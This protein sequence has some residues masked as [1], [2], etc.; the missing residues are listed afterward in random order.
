VR[1]LLPESRFRTREI[2][3]S[4]R[5]RTADDPSTIGPNDQAVLKNMRPS[6][7]YPR[8]IGGMTKVNTS[9]LASTGIRNGFHYRKG[10]PEES[11]FMVWTNNGG[12]W[13]N[14]TAIP[15]QGAF[16]SI[17]FADTAV[18]DPG[19]FSMAPGGALAYANGVE[20][21]L[22]GGTKYRCAGFVDIPNDTDSYDY[23]DQVSN[24]DEDT[25][26]VATIHTEVNG[27]SYEATFYVGSIMPI[28]G[29]YF[30]VNTVNSVAT[31]LAVSYW[32]GSAWASV[33]NLDD[34]TESG[35][36]VLAQDGW[37]TFD[38]T[39]DVAKP[40]DI[41]KTFIYWY[42]FSM[43]GS[44]TY[45]PTINTVYVDIPMQK[46]KDIW[47]GSPIPCASHLIHYSDVYHDVTT[48]TIED[49]YDNSESNTE[50]PRTFAN[51]GGNP[52]T[53]PEEYIYF[54]FPVRIMGI[55]FSIG[56]DFENADAATIEEFD[57]W[58]GNDWI[59]LTGTLSDGTATDGKTFSKSG[60]VTW[61]P[62]TSISEKTIVDLPSHSKIPPKLGGEPIHVASDVPLYYYRMKFSAVINEGNDYP[63]RVYYVSGI[64]A[65]KDIKGYAFPLCHQNRLVL[66]SNISGR[67]N[68]IL[69]SAQD[70]ANAFNGLDSY[71]FFVGNDDP[72]VAGTPLFLRVSSATQDMLV[73][74]KNSEIHL[75]EG[76]GSDS[77]PYRLRLLTDVIGCRAPLTMATVPVGDL[78]GGVRRQL[79]I[80]ES[81]RGIE[82]FDGV[83]LLDPLLS[84]DIRDKFDPNNAN[85]AGSSSNA[86]F[87]DAVYDEYHWLPV[88]S[89][90]WVYSFKYKKWYQVDRGSG[91]YLYGGIPC[92]DTSGDSYVYGFDNA[93]YVY[94]LE[95]GTDFDSNDIDH[96]IKTGAIALNENRI[97]EETVLRM[98]KVVQVAKSVTANDMT[99]T[100][101][102]DTATSGNS[103][104][105]IDPAA[106]GK[107][108]RTAIL[109]SG[110]KGPHVH[111]EFQLELTTDD[112]VSGC[113]PIYIV[114]YYDGERQDVR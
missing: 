64:P 114:A 31:S 76:N 9:A 54:G 103:V 40:K 45:A 109:N 18:G 66:C 3:L 93:G 96:I 55:T 104:G 61:S 84:H 65:P 20:S 94:R 70:T 19:R 105:T 71:E 60:W 57:Y 107:R 52:S 68:S 33:T 112:E 42:K 49:Y 25:N 23:Y 24:I 82:V 100:H 111:H 7:Q 4:G 102:G 91:K 16:S 99:V 69:I 12:V 78:G 81:Q 13:K 67:K 63:V 29:V 34:G 77:D 51:Y 14:D 47:D 90:E 74:A 2:A 108:L 26:D 80:W 43:S 97:S 41:N 1:C 38:S 15:S 110:S 39:K 6:D 37:V 28:K 50:R 32:D 85:Y 46:I 27:A 30:D 79:A 17:L 98:V 106:S 83:S 22:W 58:N 53:L 72:F 86:G 35:G 56:E 101:Y 10:Q 21:C 73:L 92:L 5:L 48:R 36:V 59:D 62:P 75:L 88:G 8:G 113:E 87:Y 95:N 89:A 44:S 11:H